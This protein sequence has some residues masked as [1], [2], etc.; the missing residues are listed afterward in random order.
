MNE[1]IRDENGRPIISKLCKQNMACADDERQNSP[2]CHDHPSPGCVY[3]CNTDRCNEQPI[4]NSGATTTTSLT[5]AQTT[6]PPTVAPVTAGQLTTA[7]KTSSSVPPTV[8]PVTAALITA[9]SKTSDPV[10]VNPVGRYYMRALTVL[11]LESCNK[12]R[13]IS[14]KCH[15]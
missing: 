14:R 4:P 8:P 10:T 2:D 11:N 12:L 15:Q 1:I 6:A 3:C 13:F 7:P 5:S 9:V